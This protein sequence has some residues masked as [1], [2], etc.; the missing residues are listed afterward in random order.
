[1]SSIDL[2][3]LAREAG[4]SITLDRNAVVL[5]G[6]TEPPQG[7]LDELRRQKAHIVAILQSE[8]E[9]VPKPSL[10]DVAT[11]FLREVKRADRK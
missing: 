6:P 5:E 8:T 11:E 4:I 9:C 7:L 2:F 1:M 3:K 10:A